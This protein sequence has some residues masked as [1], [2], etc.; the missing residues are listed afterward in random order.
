MTTQYDMWAEA[1]DPDPRDAEIAELR[2]IVERLEDSRA[3]LRRDNQLLVRM[4]RDPHLTEAII[5]EH[6]QQREELVELRA[7]VRPVDDVRARCLAL[8]RQR[9][10]PWVPVT[11]LAHRGFEEL[12]LVARAYEIATLTPEGRPGPGQ[13]ATMLVHARDLRGLRA[14]FIHSDLEVAAV[15]AAVMRRLDVAEATREMMLEGLV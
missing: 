9:R 5:I 3:E 15:R 2:E 8:I 10:N 7:C 12:A 6:R 4:N 1:L 13:R 14:G 11:K